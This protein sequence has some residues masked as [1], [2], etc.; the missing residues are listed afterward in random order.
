MRIQLSNGMLHFYQWDTKQQ[1]KAPDGVET[2]HFR[3]DNDHAAP[4][5]VVNGWATVPDECFQSGDNLVYYAYDENHTT[6]SARVEVVKRQ[7]PTGYIYTPTEIKT[8]ESLDSRI[9]KLEDG[10]VVVD[11][12]LTQDGQ[13]ADA[14]VAGQ[15]IGQLKEDKISKPTSA[16]NGKVARAKNGS[17]EWVDVGQPTDQQTESAVTNWLDKHPEATTTVQD[18]AIGEEKINVNFLPW[19]KKDYATPEMFGAKGDG[20]SDDTAAIQTALNSGKN[21]LASNTYIISDT[22]TI[23]LNATHHLL[24]GKFIY[25][26]TD[27]AF[28]LKKCQ[29]GATIQFGQVKSGGDALTLIAGL[30]GENDYIQYL[31]V[32]FKELYAGDGKSCIKISN[33][34]KWITECT[35]RGGR[36]RHGQYGIFV[37]KGAGEVEHHKYINCGFEIVKG[38]AFLDKCQSFCFIYPRISE[39]KFFL[40]TKNMCS[41]LS[42]MMA[43]PVYPEYFS[44]SEATNGYIIGPLVSDKY[45]YI[46]GTC[47]SPIIR[48]RILPQ[49]QEVYLNLVQR[50]GIV[51]ISD[52]AT[53]YRDVPNAINVP[54]KITTLILN[55]YYGTNCGINEIIVQLNQTQLRTLTI[56]KND[57]VI[58]I[59]GKEIPD[60][61]YVLLKWVGV[62]G[63]FCQ[64]LRKPNLKPE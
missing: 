45:D 12:T 20:V 46:G 32:V 22:I 56:K 55:D 53:N 27:T 63:W 62:Y 54:D 10:G 11:A 28:K 51:N 60:Y 16:D 21:V 15:E 61:S 2:I 41:E 49:H 26:G 48:G 4:V 23:N 34:T 9:K 43:Q 40:T 30:D 38:G 25:T 59:F 18:G 42:I 35:F 5:T 36:F 31:E 6:D 64:I 39:N 57:D 33:N 8:W 19:I 13:A 37:N 24:I 52:V 58:G 7:K 47:F 1:V 44:F 29:D 14:K 50:E 17:V 3:I